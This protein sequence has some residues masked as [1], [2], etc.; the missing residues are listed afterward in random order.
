MKTLALVVLTLMAMSRM[1]V[2]PTR[3]Q[4]ADMC[5]HDDPTVEALR[6]CVEHAIDHGHIDDAEVAQSLL[7]KLDA[8]QAA[9]ERRQDTPAVNILRAF[10]PSVEAQAGKSVLEPHA[11]HLVA[12]VQIVIEELGV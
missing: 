7:D 4:E 12:H 10:I 9:V 1:A 5:A 8:A 2:T 6:D 3:T 11:G